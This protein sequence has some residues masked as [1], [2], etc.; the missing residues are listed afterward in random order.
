[1]L[2]HVAGVPVEEFL[3]MLP[4]G[5]L[6]ALLAVLRRPPSRRRSQTRTDHGVHSGRNMKSSDE[7]EGAKRLPEKQGA[8]NVDPCTH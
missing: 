4:I 7:E 3:S 2:A 5:G 6:L 8:S 1:M